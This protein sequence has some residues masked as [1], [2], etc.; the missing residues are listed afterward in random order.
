MGGYTYY[1][2][3]QVKDQV[4]GK[5]ENGVHDT[6]A[7]ARRCLARQCEFWML[8]GPNCFTQ[9][10]TRCMPTPCTLHSAHCSSHAPCGAQVIVELL[11][12]KGKLPSFD[13]RGGTVLVAC[14]DEALRGTAMR[15]AAALRASGVDVDM[16]LDAKKTK[17]V[18]KHADRTGARFVALVAPDEA[19]RGLVR[20]KRMGDGEQADVEL[21][22]LPR[23]VAE[24]SA[25]GRA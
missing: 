14:Q 20:V 12:E 17:W 13:Q 7:C 24:Q 18:F 8:D 22:E 9:G 19:E 16:V 4:G 6:G 11:K 1:H 2:I 3:W 23:W 10:H 15:A 5:H 25:A 21:G